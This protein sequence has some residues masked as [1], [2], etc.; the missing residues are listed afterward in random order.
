MLL[1][2]WMF[3]FIGK[4]SLL[5]LALLG[6]TVLKEWHDEY[7]IA[8]LSPMVYSVPAMTIVRRLKRSWI[9]SFY[10]FVVDSY[11]AVKSGF[12]HMLNS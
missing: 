11:N 4:Q 8:T 12:T 1:S 3:T 9:W 7:I 6:Q 5:K 2:S 10:Q